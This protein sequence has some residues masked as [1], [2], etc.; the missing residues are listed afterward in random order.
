MATTTRSS[1]KAAQRPLGRNPEWWNKDHDSAWERV[2]DALH[3]DWEQTK[4]D[5]GGNAPDLNQSVGDT[6]SQAAGKQSIPPENVPNYE[7][8]EPAMRYGYGARM[9]YGERY[10]EW[11][12]DLDRELRADWPEDYDRSRDAIRYG[13]SYSDLAAKTPNLPR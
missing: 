5:F 12:E 9:H 11:S 7:E 10:P 3:R 6:V 13:W 4:H 2:K 1:M 8:F